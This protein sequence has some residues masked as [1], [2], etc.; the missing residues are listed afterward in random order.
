MVL[1]IFTES[2]YTKL[3]KIDNDFVSNI[4]DKMLLIQGDSWSQLSLIFLKNLKEEENQLNNKNYDTN[5]ILKLLLQ[6][7]TIKNINSTSGNLKYVEKNIEYVI[8]NHLKKVNAID[9]KSYYELKNILF[10]IE[11]ANYN[12]SNIGNN[13][14]VFNTSNV[15][16]DLSIKENIK[17]IY[18]NKIIKKSHLN[19]KEILKNIDTI[20]QINLVNKN[21]KNTSIKNINLKD[22]GRI[23]LKSIENISFK[24]VISETI[25]NTGIML[26]KVIDKNLLVVNIIKKRT[27]EEVSFGITSSIIFK[28]INKN[29]DDILIKEL[30]INMHNYKKTLIK[31]ID[32]LYLLRQQ[33]N[34]NGKTEKNYNLNKE[35]KE[36]YFI[37]QQIEKDK[38]SSF[39]MAKNNK[40]IHDETEILNQIEMMKNI[41]IVNDIYKKERKLINLIFKEDEIRKQII[42]EKINKIYIRHE[43]SNLKNEFSEEILLNESKHNNN[44]V[45]STSN[46]SNNVVLKESITNM[47]NLNNI[48]YSNKYIKKY[49]L[50]NKKIVKN[51]YN[52]KQLNFVIKNIKNT[53]LAN[54][55]D[56]NFENTEKINLKSIENI[57]FKNVISETI[58]NSGIMLQK[59]TDK[60]LF[61]VEIIKKRALEEL[62][63]GITSSIIFKNVNKNQDDILVKELLINMHNYKKTLIKEIDELHLLRQQYNI[64]GKTEKNYNLNKEIKEKYFIKQQIEKDKIVFFEM[65][66]NNKIIHDET[67]ILNQFKMMKNINIVNDIYKK[68]RKLINIS[69]KEDEIRKQIIEEKINKIDIRHEIRNLKDELSEEILLNENK[70]NN[71][72]VIRTSNASNDVVLKENTT[73]IETLNNIIYNDKYPLNN[74]K[75]VKNIYTEKQLNF[76]IKNIKNTNLENI[77][78]INFKNTK[79]INLKSIEKINFKNVISKTI[80]NSS[81]MLQKIVNDNLFVVNIIKKRTLEEV[82]FGITSSTIL[83]N[84]SKSQE[85][86][87]VKELLITMHNYKETLIKEIDE[88]QLLKEQYNINKKMVESYSLNKE[89][90]EKHFISQQ[91]QENKISSFKLIKSNRIIHDETEILN[92][93]EMMKNINIVN[94]IYKKERKLINL[95]FKEDEIRKQIIEEKINKI[96]IRHEIR[97]LKNEFN[98]EILLNESKHNNNSIIRT[99]NVSNDVIFKKNTKSVENLNNIIYSNKAMQKYHMNNKKIFRNIYTEKQL[100]LV[101]KY[102]KNI[103]SKNIENVNFKNIISEAITNNGVM[104]QRLRTQNSLIGEIIKKQITE[105]KIINTNIRNEIKKIKSNFVEE[106]LLSE[107][108]LYIASTNVSVSKM[109]N[110]KSLTMNTDI[111]KNVMSCAEK[112]L[113]NHKKLHIEEQEIKDGYDSVTN[114]NYKKN[115]NS[116]TNYNADQ[117]QINEARINEQQ[118]NKVINDTVEKIIENKLSSITQVK[119]NNDEEKIDNLSRKVIVKIEKTLD[120]ERRRR[121]L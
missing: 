56:I 6:L 11:N 70:H 92:K 91:M 30:L 25:N 74:K 72:S 83:K 28:N 27:L 71:N 34:I 118:I 52:E 20:K 121:G 7:N 100:K 97:N 76:V 51:I 102:I 40:I 106:I 9:S 59:I 50:N 99:S 66:K 22:T 77:K 86:I 35:I 13:N 89:E 103:N 49:P 94:N 73:N 60:N 95:S 112:L 109:K 82:S 98:E 107:N 55:K 69:F 31:E 17:K 120:Y 23:Y 65:A 43:I 48:I 115:I 111:Y 62:R 36:K 24:N 105:E 21:I 14:S 46:A 119:N 110:K 63:F 45:I 88:L 90:K 8:K 32:E 78:D 84:I 16:N 33:Y 5:L 81:I 2:V 44:L 104:L 1:N 68:E 41:N 114:M 117:V 87:L 4:F 61:V 116:D 96:D 101:S 85:N 18:S 53:N 93:F 37:K 12:Y 3:I 10:Q 15:T 79:K 29:Q 108:K 64:S 39:E 80:N 42:Q 113:I 57:N 67:E 54:I 26:Q 75:I 19:N 58:N 47:E 38:I